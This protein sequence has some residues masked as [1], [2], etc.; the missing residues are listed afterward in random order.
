MKELNKLGNLK[1]LNKDQL[2]DEMLK[3][4]IKGGCCSSITHIYGP[5]SDWRLPSG[6]IVV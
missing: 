1:N 3:G 5:N 4:S 6:T 2:V